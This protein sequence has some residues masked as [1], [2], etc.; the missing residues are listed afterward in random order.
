MV[1][2]KPTPPLS[3]KSGRACE[4]KLERDK[5]DKYYV[6]WTD[7]AYGPRCDVFTADSPDEATTEVSGYDTVEGPFDT[8][9]EAEEIA[10]G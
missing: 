3:L 2:F 4:L 10:A 8:I 1:L 6:G 5:M 9:E 7:S